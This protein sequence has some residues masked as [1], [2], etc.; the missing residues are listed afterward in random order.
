MTKTTLARWGNSLGVRIPQ[1]VAE[2][3]HWQA[4]TQVSVH[5]TDLGEVL[6]RPIPTV[7][8]LDELTADITEDNRPATV[9][10]GEPVGREAL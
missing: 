5:L 4:G 7:P 3:A 2:K 10:W 1:A 8:T 6:L 9:D